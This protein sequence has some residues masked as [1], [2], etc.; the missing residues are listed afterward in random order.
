MDCHD[1]QLPARTH[2]VGPAQSLEVYAV[3]LG[4]RQGSVPVTVIGL[5]VP[6]G[7]GLHHRQVNWSELGREV[8]RRVQD[9]GV[10]EANGD[11]KTLNDVSRPPNLLLTLLLDHHLVRTAERTQRSDYKSL[12]TEKNLILSLLSSHYIV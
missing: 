11:G 7:E 5:V 8:V 4:G 3:A 6:Y 9:G 12:K 10:P 2:P 1:W